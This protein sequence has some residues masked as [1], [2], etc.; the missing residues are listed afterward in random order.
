MY[1]II[2]ADG[3]EY[4]PGSAEQIRQ[5]IVEGRAHAQTL[6]KVEG[7]AEWKPLASFPELLQKPAPAAPSVAPV[8]LPRPSTNG[9]AIAGLVMGILSVTPFGWFCCIPLFSVL[10]IIFSSRALSQIRRNPLQE[11]GKGIATTALV[12]SILGL[13][14]PLF[15][16][17]L[18]GATRM[19]GR[20]PFYWHWYRSW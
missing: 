1:K 11:T 16:A 13:I 17:A 15:L 3:R 20:R 18:L 5:W 6:T 7:T 9:S 19:L 12:L 14:A 10:G 2:G 4:G 8:V